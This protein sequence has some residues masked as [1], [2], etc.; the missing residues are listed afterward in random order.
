MLP[1]ATGEV[2]PD[3]EWKGYTG[4]GFAKGFKAEGDAIEFKVDVETAGTYDLV[5]RVNNGKKNDPQYDSSPRTGGLYIQ[6]DKAADLSFEITDVW[7]Q[8]D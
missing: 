8:Y 4:S 1:T 3:N 7:G 6:G 2:K 5:L